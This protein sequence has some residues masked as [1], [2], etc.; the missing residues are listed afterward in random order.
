MGSATTIEEV[1]ALFDAFRKQDETAMQ[2]SAI[3]L[4]AEFLT[5]VSRIADAVEKLADASK[6]DP[7]AT[8]KPWL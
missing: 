7:V 2:A 6:A 4:L 8:L 5:N 1:A 3:M